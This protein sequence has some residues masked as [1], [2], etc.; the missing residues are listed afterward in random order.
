MATDGYSSRK[1]RDYVWAVV[2][3]D[4]SMPESK[5]QFTI[6]EAIPDSMTVSITTATDAPQSR[7]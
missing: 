4:P 6:T 1:G 2:R 3:Y 7:K 5:T